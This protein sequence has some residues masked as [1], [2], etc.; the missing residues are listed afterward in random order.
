MFCG[1]APNQSA[2]LRASSFRGVLRFWFRA[3]AWS[4]ATNGDLKKVHSLEEALFGSAA[5]GRGALSLSLE[6]SPNPRGGNPRFDPGARYLGYGVVDTKGNPQ[7]KLLPAGCEFR[8]RM[9]LRDESLKPALLRA[10]EA[11]GLLGGLGAKSRKGYGSI[12]LT[13]LCGDWGIPWIPP[14]SPKE[15]EGRIRSLRPQR[16]ESEALP[17][18]T[19]VSGRSRFLIVLGKAGQQPLDLLDGIGR[20]IVC[21]RSLGRNKRI[22]DGKPAE[23]DKRT[24]R[25]RFFDDHILVNKGASG[26]PGEHPRRIAFGLPHNYGKSKHEKVEA[27]GKTAA[28][29]TIDRRAS[30]LF[31]HI[32][33]CG[34]APAAV[35]SFLPAAFLPDGSKIK[36]GTVSVE[37]LADPDIWQPVRD[38]FDRLVHGPKDHLKPAIEI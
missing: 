6:T 3:A 11:A 18:Y 33:Q 31:I 21:Y 20:E 4:E 10:V 29:K 2:E 22:L 17:P 26:R 32:H 27:A 1:G 9:R 16:S 38:L 35:L 36:V 24:G 7:R 12:C 25:H 5:A 37:P 30:P 34:G 19:A 13:K 28:G 8:V 14:N 15:I 23:V